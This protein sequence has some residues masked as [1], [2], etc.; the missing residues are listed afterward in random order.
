MSGPL[1]GIRVIDVTTIFLGPYATQM[2]GDMGADVIKVEP[3]QGDSTRY[4]GA[5]RHR[6]MG[7]AFLN[8][9]RNKRSLALDLK[10]DGGKRA[11]RR[12]IA[13][14]D[15]LI[16]N[17]R[18]RAMARLG[19]GYDEV[20][21]LKPDI[22]YCAAHGYAADGPYGARPAYD[23]ALQAESGLA[24]LFRA[25]AGEP[26]FVP[27]IVVDKMVGV[28]AAQAVA[29]A[30]VHR[31]RTGEGQA[32]EVP[33][34]ET[35]VSFLM[36]EHLYDRAFVPPL[37]PA[38]Y[39]RVTTPLRRPYR[40]R[41]GHVCI[42]PYSDSQWHDFFAIAGRPEMKDDPRFADFTTRNEHVDTLYGF[43]AAV[44]PERTTEEWLALCA[45]A[46]IPA[47]PVNALND[48]FDD[49]HLKATDFFRPLAHPSEGD[50]VIASPPIAMSRTPGSIRRPAPALGEHGA[51]VL[52]EIGYGAADIDAL[53]A[54]GA[55][56]QPQPDD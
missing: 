13:T 26:L 5:A 50:T 53:A 23:D 18:P 9:N 16:H 7:G 49:P 48:L 39:T 17:M 1:D 38:G 36:V 30:L 43:I 44:A 35:L 20:A 56:I 4:L 54:E 32:V 41:D 21:A 34:F 8:L 3:R 28:F 15:V 10:R 31:A 47:A 52:R 2:L 46:E 25:S 45:E 33:M 29:L 14:A 6:G 12:L 19:F 42:L 24:D 55:L 51:E 27:T 40:T 11:L 37:G 22:V